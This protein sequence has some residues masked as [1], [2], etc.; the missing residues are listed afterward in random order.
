M[1][2]TQVIKTIA[3]TVASA[4]GGPLAGMAVS[5]LGSIFGISEPTQD[6]IKDAIT[7]AQMTPEQVAQIKALELQY[8]N[9][10][11]ERQFKYA[12]LE[13]KDLD[14]ARQRDMQTK[15]NVNRNLAYTIVAAFIALVGATL[16]GV[17]KVDSV[18]AGTLVGYLSAKCEQVLAYYFG[19]SRGSE[20]KSE[21]LAAA[22]PAPK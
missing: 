19:S 16:L 14:S 8:Q 7:N 4:L 20:R 5:A 15:D 9:D 11:K 21:L 6:K 1:D 18:L 3:P 10:E 22:T 12:E 13:F 17:A 2:F